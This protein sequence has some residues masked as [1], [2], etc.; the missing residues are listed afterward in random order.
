MIDESR[1][2]NVENQLRSL[3]QLAQEARAYLSQQRTLG[4]MSASDIDQA[5]Q[6][7]N[8][9]IAAKTAV[10]RSELNAAAVLV[11]SYVDEI[12]AKLA[13]MAAQQ[14]D[15]RREIDQIKSGER[16]TINRAQIVKTIEE[17]GL[18]NG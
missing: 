6:A 2:T 7:L 13:M 1:L 12:K 15:L 18:T 10:I 8:T 17:L 3:N 4:A 11:Q 9:Q 14:D 16:Y 5:V